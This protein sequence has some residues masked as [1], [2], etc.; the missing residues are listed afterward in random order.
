MVYIFLTPG[1]EPLEA[2]APMDILR[3]ARIEAEFVSV[4]GL[5]IPESTQGYG[6]GTDIGWD[7]FLEEWNG[8]DNDGNCLIF[9]GGLPGAADLGGNGPLMALTR[10]HFAKGGLVCA[11]CAAPAKVVARNLPVRGRRMTVYAG[12]EDEL[13]QAGAIPTG[14]SVTEDGNL[15]TG[16]GPGVALEFGFAI[17]RRLADPRVCDVVRKAMM[18]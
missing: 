2:L 5:P 16:K 17:L 3:R 6:I 10:E 1:Y 14:E 4:G 11:I 15:I 12:F 7:D 8:S 18:L 13:E 9:P